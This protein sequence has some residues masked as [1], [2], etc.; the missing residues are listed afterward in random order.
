MQVIFR[1]NFISKEGKLLLLPTIVLAVPLCL[2]AFVVGLLVISNT[3]LAQDTDT[4]RVNNQNTTS[5]SNQQSEFTV[6]DKTIVPANQTTVKANITVIP[7]VNNT[8][9]TTQ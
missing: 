6:V 1:P 2:A 3:A 9:N 8:S 4:G 5:A 7:L